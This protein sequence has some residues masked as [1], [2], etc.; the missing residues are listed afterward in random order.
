[1]VTLG[2]QE[3]VIDGVNEAVSVTEGVQVAG[4]N[5]VALAEGVS[6]VV[7]VNVGVEVLVIVLVRIVAVGVRVIVKVIVGVSVRVGVRLPGDG[8]RAIAINPMQ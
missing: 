7:G 4:W 5:K 2:V 8:L 6:V 1:M 3:G